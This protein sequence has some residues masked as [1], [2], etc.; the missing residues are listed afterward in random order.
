M[1][2]KLSLIIP[3]Y[4]VENYISDCI[5]SLQSQITDEVEVIIVD[6][7]SKDN[8]KKILDELIFNLPKSKSKQFKVFSQKNQ[9]QSAAR[10]FGITQAKGDYIAFVDSDDILNERYFQ[11]TISVLKTDEPD[12]LRI[13][14]Q[15]FLNIPN[16]IVESESFLSY[17]GLKPINDNLLIEMFNQGNW[18]ICLYI[19]KKSLIINERF[20]EGVYFEDANLVPKLLLNAKNIYFLNEVLYLYRT[21]NK[22]SLR[23]MN[24]KNLE[25]LDRSYKNIINIYKENLKK[26]PAYGIGLVSFS[27]LYFNFLK[28]H[29]NL[30]AAFRQ[31][32]KFLE[33]KK[34]ID[35]KLIK[36]K[37]GKLYIKYGL[38][39]IVAYELKNLMFRQG[40]N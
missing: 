25:K 5:N 12:I 37:S 40:R 11:K 30:H 29:K 18:Y 19:F 16:E 3:M 17:D 9:G 31:H 39:F 6:D 22:G 35:S 34:T 26:Q 2:V 33:D 36:N 20:Q 13:S 27:L 23:S 21:N 24:P 28:S 14:F 38:K 7:G 32:L 15:R 1:N 8:S 10:N 4:N